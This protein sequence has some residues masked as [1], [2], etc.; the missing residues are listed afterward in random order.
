V[1]F[2]YFLGFFLSIVDIGIDIVAIWLWLFGCGYLVVAIWLWLFWL[3]GYLGGVSLEG[4]V[5]MLFCYVS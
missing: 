2:F 5:I 1:F 3:F 4:M